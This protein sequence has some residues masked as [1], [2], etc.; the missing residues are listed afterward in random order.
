MTINRGDVLLIDL[1][2]V[3]GSEQGKTRPCL[4]VQN[5]IGNKFAPTTIIA[6]ITSN[7][8]KSYPFTVFV[9]QG[10]GNLTKDS[11]VL[12]NQIRTISTQDRLVKKLG[13]FKADTMKKVNEALKNSLALD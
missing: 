9:K 8:G 7:T 13:S 12:C 6:A 11:L 4:V 3:K 2:P 1:D 10:D 5:D